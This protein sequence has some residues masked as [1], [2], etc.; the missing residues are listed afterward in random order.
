VFY[1]YIYLVRDGEQQIF[2]LFRHPTVGDL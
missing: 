2:V 1:I